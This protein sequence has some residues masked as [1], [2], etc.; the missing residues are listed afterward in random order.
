MAAFVLSTYGRFLGVHRGT[1]APSSFMVM[2][3]WPQVRTI[4]L[5]T[6]T[7]RFLPT[8]RDSLS[9]TGG[10]EVR[11]DLPMCSSLPIC[12]VQLPPILVVVSSPTVVSQS[13]PILVVRLGPNDSAWLGPRV[14]A[15]LTP[16]VTSWLRPS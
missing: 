14:S 4:S 13:V 2:T 3:D 10:L 15:R 9:P 8:L 7:C 5:P 16:T 11:P 1:R 6:V 12:V